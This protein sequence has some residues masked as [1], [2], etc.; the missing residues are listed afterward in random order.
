[1][2]DPTKAA[3]RKKGAA[4]RAIVRALAR[5]ALATRMADDGTPY[6]SL[7]MTACDP[8]GSPLILLSD[9]AEHTK[10]LK[11]RPAA[12]LLFD[13]TAG[14]EN[15]LTGTRVT[16]SGSISREPSVE[17]FAARYISRHPDAKLY[18]GFADFNLYRMTVA[19]VHVV[20]G[21]GQIHWLAGEHF[22][23]DAHQA[24]DL[25]DA[26]PDIIAHMNG[27]H[28]EAVRL[29]ATMLGGS[30]GGA[31]QLAGIDCDGIDLRLGNGRARIPFDRPVLTADGARKA[32]AGLAQ[33]ARKMAENS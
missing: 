2:T 31:W 17:I 8:A 24:A 14:L 10:N 28:A 15:A 29:Y 16:L 13:A 7:V 3:E 25:T 23:A 22:L 6:A 32:L 26:E 33:K 20:A 18:A 12:S 5:A 11:A 21:F 27:D 30:A 1:M 4:A 9:L 19:R